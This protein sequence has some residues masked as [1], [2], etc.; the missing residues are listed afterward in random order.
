[1]TTAVFLTT[2]LGLFA[3]VWFFKAKGFKGKAPLLAVFL[4]GIFLATMIGPEV[5]SGTVRVSDGAVTTV[6]GLFKQP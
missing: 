4:A 3:L 6:S 2:A 5:R 1:M